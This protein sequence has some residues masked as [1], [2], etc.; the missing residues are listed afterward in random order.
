MDEL[1]NEG[2]LS[3]MLEE[4]K[5]RMQ[6]IIDKYGAEA[7]L[8]SSTDV[9]CD[10]FENEFKI[11]PLQL[12]VGSV[13]IDDQETQM[14]VR[15]DPNRWISDKSR[16]FF[17]GGLSI[18]YYV[19]Y[20]GDPVLFRYQPPRYLIKVFRGT[21]ENGNLVI[22]VTRT[23]QDKSTE[24]FNKEF[25]REIADI[26]KM[27]ASAAESINSYNQE[28]RNLVRE[29]VEGRRNKLLAD[30]NLVSELGFPLRRQSDVPRAA[31]VPIKRKQIDIVKPA[32]SQPVETP[33]K[34][35]WAIE[36]EVY[37]DIL[38][39][40]RDLSI[41]MERSPSTFTRL[42]EEEIRDFILI[43]LNAQFKGQA[44]AETFNYGGKT[45]ILI[46]HDNRNIFIAECKFWSGQKGFQE[47]I[48]QILS[49]SQ[50]RDC[51][52]AILLF[53]RNKNFTSV[54]N[55]MRVATQKHPNFRR[56]I[57]NGGDTMYKCNVHHPDDVQRE[58]ILTTLAF[59]IPDGKTT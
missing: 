17:V 52:L 14:D 20:S 13:T 18:R 5:R 34:P 28:L 12:D 1:F 33:F 16:P 38:N 35:E 27:V 9:L 15:N 46:R 22:T 58:M 50:W 49:Y 7:L 45:D 39:V 36:I 32:S 41:A 37:E 4:R 26:Q 57:D 11:D 48:D 19:P 59:E 43:I 31:T 10:Q 54:I 6:L 21:I 51:K 30:R 44:T 53:N 42:N 2:D 8:Q 29:H 40:I 47:T 23:D 25:N 55:S 3:T 24:S 56:E